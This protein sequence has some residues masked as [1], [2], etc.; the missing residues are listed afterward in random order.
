[1]KLKSLVASC[2]IIS[3]IPWQP[4]KAHPAAIAAPAICASGV[5]CVLVLTA[6]V[7]G[8]AQYVWHISGIDAAKQGNAHWGSERSACQSMAR[9]NHWKL[10]R[11][12]PANGGGYWCI[13]SGE[14]TDFGGGN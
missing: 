9:R 10:V 2:L 5:G 8:I 3:I 1:M 11:V 4:A 13:F 6:V 14:Q 12:I 7:G